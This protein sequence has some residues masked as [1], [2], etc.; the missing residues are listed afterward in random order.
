MKVNRFDWSLLRVFLVI[1]EEK[2][3][4]LASFKL[5]ITQSAVSQNL[6]KLEEQLEVK[7]I[8]RNNRNFYLTEQGEILYKTA[9]EIY[10]K[11]TECENLLLSSQNNLKGNLNL[12]MVT[13][14]NSPLLDRQLTSFRKE[15]LDIEL[16][17]QT[18]SHSEI[19]NRIYN[20]YPCLAFTLDPGEENNISKL[21]YIP[22]R[23]SFYC[24]ESHPLFNKAEI[25]IEDIFT[26]NYVA[27]DSEELGGAL[28]SIT[29]FR[30]MKSFIAKPI[31]KTNNLYE[32]RRL[33]KTGYGVGALP[34]NMVDNSIDKKRLRKLPPYQGIADMP[35][36]IVWN[37]E[38]TLKPTE[39]A[40]LQFFS[41]KN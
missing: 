23:Y 30:K 13:G 15:F 6:K 41:S 36:F 24:G 5:N 28:S 38:R 37:N 2:S 27:F 16:T 18:H 7:L 31:A 21:F 20:N 3:L 40:F 10:S 29:A 12:M 26:Q 11:L 22:Q 17:I 14:I 25:S 19:L 9:V 35:I 1:V 34:D 4:S 39:Q 8:V 32:L 33:I